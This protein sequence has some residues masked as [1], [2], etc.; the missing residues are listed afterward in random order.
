MLVP[1]DGLFETHLTVASL[2]L[3]VAFYRD[4]LGLELAFRLDERRVAFFWLGERGRSMVGLWE[5]GSAPNTLHLHLAFRCA[6]L[7][8]LAAPERLRAAGVTPLG[9]HGEPVNQPVVIGWMPAASVFFH[10]PDGHLLEFLAM[11][12]DQ[13]RA[14]IGVVSYSEWSAGTSS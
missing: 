13:P 3:S 9:F 1:I 2:D 11:L 4:V 12:P 6:L 10:D 8:V 5:T 14:N 7:D